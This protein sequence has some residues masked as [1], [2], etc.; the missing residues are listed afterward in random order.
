MGFMFVG[1]AMVSVRL[2]SR[3][4][5]VVAVLCASQVDGEDLSRPQ[6]NLGDLVDHGTAVDEH[7]EVGGVLGIE[8]GSEDIILGFED[9]TL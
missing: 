7:G 4:W 6:S 5:V 9:D 2:P 1:D 3:N 8:S